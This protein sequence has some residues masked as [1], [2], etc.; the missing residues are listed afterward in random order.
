MK[1]AHLQG[2][3]RRSSNGGATD[4]PATTRSG[5]GP[6]V[7]RVDAMEPRRPA[8]KQQDALSFVDNAAADQFRDDEVGEGFR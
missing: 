1:L 5:V 2:A 7:G 6:W 3:V 4:V 8:P